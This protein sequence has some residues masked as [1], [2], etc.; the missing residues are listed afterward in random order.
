MSIAPLTSA[1]ES[2]V[3]LDDLAHR[4]PVYHMPL[5]FRILGA[6]DVAALERAL[7]AVVERHEAL[8]T[9]IVAAPEGLRQEARASRFSLRL[10]SI[11]P[12]ELTDRL[13]QAVE[14]PFDLS[15]GRPFRADLFRLADEAHVLLLN[16]HHALGDMTSLG[17]IVRELGQ[18]YAGETLPLAGAQSGAYAAQCQSEPSAETRAFWRDALRDCVAE[19]GLVT[20]RARPR[21][22]SFAG[23][24][25]WR[26]LPQT[27]VQALK[28][29]AR[30]KRCSVFVLTLAALQALVRR[31]TGQE[32]FCIASP[33]SDRVDPAFEATVGCLVNLLPIPCRVSLEQPF[34]DLLERARE[35]ALASMEHH[36]IS[37]RRIMRELNLSSDSLKPALARVVFQYFPEVPRLELRGVQSTALPLH[38]STSKFDLC[39]SL[40]ETAGAI[41]I[42]TEYDSDLFER[43]TAERWTAHFENIL[44]SVCENINQALG[45]L[46]LGSAEDERLIAEWNDTGADYPKDATIP[47][48]F[49]EIAAARPDAT[50]IVSEHESI[51]YRELDERANAVANELLRQ[52]VKPGEF[53]GL[54][55]PRSPMLVAAIIGILKAGAAYVPFDANYPQARLDYLFIDTAVRVLITNEELARIAP[56]RINLLFIDSA[57]R[58]LIA[59]EQKLSALSAAYVMHTSGSTG[60]PKGVLVPHRAI[61]RLVRGN[62]FAMFGPEEVWLAFAPVSFD[63]S[64]LELWGPLLN[65][66]VLALY[67]PDFQSVE[68]FEAV[69]QKHRVTS[70]WLTA[71]LFHTIVDQRI[72][73]LRGL[74]QLLAGGDVLSVA[75]VRKA[76]LALPGTRI[77]NGYGPTEN[78]TFTCCFEIPRD[79]PEGRAIPIGR[80]IRNTRVY[81]LDEAMKPVPVGVPG[82]LWTAGDG[83]SLGYLNQPKLTAASFVQWRG[84]R[85]YR[86]GD[87]ARW[88][89]DGLIDFLGRRDS[90]VK[91]RGFRVELGEIEEV[92][93]KQPG[94][95]DAA[96]AV[97]LDAGGGKQI[98]AY[99]VA[100]AETQLDIE[101]VRSKLSDAL[102]AHACPSAILPIAQLPLGPNGKVN[103]EALPKPASLLLQSAS[104]LEANPPN[105][106]EAK[107]AE[108][109]RQILEIPSV[110]LDDNFFHLGG[111]SLR[112]TRAISQINRAFICQLTLPKIFEAPTVRQMAAKVAQARAGQI[113]GEIT[114]GRIRAAN[115]HDS[116]VLPIDV[117][118][119]SDEEVDSLLNQL[120]GND[121]E[122]QPCATK[123]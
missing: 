14:E 7:N 100:E 101:L 94:V 29:T 38:T 55:L 40:F 39:F 107:L 45:T 52:G 114:E 96:V 97:H 118:G 90:Q 32:K 78:T 110:R 64:T 69:L 9:A 46:Q 76:L 60:E 24:V 5:A 43:G 84:Q 75:H 33:V 99:L 17:V 91:I 15:S 59:P 93:R 113:M 73:A 48:L 12:G 79:W 35:Q 66:G 8:R 16:L 28:Q 68:Q 1:Q 89:A 87:R 22:P 77:I 80:P 10:H 26:E 98:A 13:T 117:E 83:L 6:L 57:N 30:Q 53:V 25:V 115:D 119:L 51:T 86:T 72:E 104:E 121:S 62:D 19:L 81:I 4:R 111:E 74:R 122:K 85:L 92:L 71:G 116:G 120:I 2:I 54:C 50:A 23:D 88:R 11:S 63:A 3:F 42:E 106:I 20:D 44:R 123:P 95:R 58:S 108:I 112:A 109:W 34:S 56:A 41:T 67:P 70:L 18:A 102:P 61:V 36:G 105:E 49:S 103:R 47:Q 65:G 31:E 82:E 27:L 21:I 37:F